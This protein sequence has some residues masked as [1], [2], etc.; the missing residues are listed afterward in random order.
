M[1][2]Y[3]ATVVGFDLTGSTPIDGGI[4]DL[5][6][7]F[8][9]DGAIL[10][11]V[12]QMGTR[13]APVLGVNLGRLGFLAAATPEQFFSACAGIANGNVDVASHLM[14]DCRLDGPNGLHRNRCL[15]EV[16][17]SAG[18]PFIMT[19]VD[20]SIDGE[21]VTT[22]S[23]DGL[24]LSTPI[25]STAHSLAAGGPILRQGLEAVVITPVCPH[26][27]TW[28]PLVEAA[29]RK[30]EL[31]VPNANEGTTLLIDGFIQIQIHPDDVIAVERSDVPF[32]LAYLKGQGYYQ[33]L[34]QKLHWG[35]RPTR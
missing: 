28:R 35:D 5:A 31:R 32:R 17:I 2:R 24:I 14:L 23:G 13:P 18:A 8:G 22:F 10:R 19:E 20:L 16:M 27:L 1:L 12:N 15:N 6:I 29:N 4:A 30:F 33:T 25:G 3:G 7:V 21:A 9:G 34:S 11:A 26:T